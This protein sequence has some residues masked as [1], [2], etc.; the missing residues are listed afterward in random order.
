MLLA[1]SGDLSWPAAT[2][3]CAFFACA[4]ACVWAAVFQDR[5]T[6]TLVRHEVDNKLHHTTVCLCQRPDEDEDDED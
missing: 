5:R 6:T 2:A 4:A 1:D 3:L